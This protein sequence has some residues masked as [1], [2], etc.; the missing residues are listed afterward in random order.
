MAA[1]PIHGILS[2]HMVPLDDRGRID[3]AG[4]P[5]LRL[6]TAVDILLYGR[7]ILMHEN[8]TGH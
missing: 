1:A 8:D 2:P 3:E 5:T 7:Y 4:I 6:K